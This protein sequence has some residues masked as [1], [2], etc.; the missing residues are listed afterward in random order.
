MNLPELLILSRGLSVEIGIID[1]TCCVCGDKTETG[2][3]ADFSGNFT[4]W[5]VLKYGDCICEKCHVLFQD[6]IYRRSSWL[7]TVD[8]FKTGKAKE[9][10]TFFEA[11]EY[12]FAMYLTWSGKKQGYL[13]LIDSVNMSEYVTIA[14]DYDIYSFKVSSFVKFYNEVKQLLEKKVMKYELQTGN[15]RLKTLEILGRERIE[16]LDRRK[17]VRLWQLAIK[18]A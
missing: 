4:N 5:D 3:K 9:L 13:Y 10:I 15:F 14:F 12:P 11:P 8:E 16:E 6:Q 17:G 1:G 7:A 2:H 18:L